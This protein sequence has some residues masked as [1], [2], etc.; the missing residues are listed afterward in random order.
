MQELCNFWLFIGWQPGGI[1]VWKHILMEARK[2]GGYGALSW[3]SFYPGELFLA[4]PKQ[5]AFPQ[6]NGPETPE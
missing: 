3:K 6:Q 1:S 4:T 5:A 2:I